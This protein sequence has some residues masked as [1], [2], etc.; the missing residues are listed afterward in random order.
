MRVRLVRKLADRVD[1]V[2]LTHCDVG[3]VI[4]L[5]EPDGRL[6]IAEQWGEFARRQ[7]DLE[8]ARERAVGGSSDRRQHE[9]RLY[10]RLNEDH[11]LDYHDRRQHHR[12]VTDDPH[13]SP[14]SAA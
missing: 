5:P 2:D 11:E 12:R 1:G 13:S 4:E 9:S 6:V 7:A 3:E 14:P 10:R 8:Q